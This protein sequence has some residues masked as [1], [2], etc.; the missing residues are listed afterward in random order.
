MSA[1][2]Y[3]LTTSSQNVRPRWQSYST[4]F[5]FRASG[6]LNKA[7]AKDRCKFNRRLVPV[8]NLAATS[9]NKTH[10]VVTRRI[11]AKIQRLHLRRGPVTSYLLVLAIPADSV[12]GALVQLWL[13]PLAGRVCVAAI[14]ATL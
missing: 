2:H 11:V 13:D 3:V 1:D 4:G 9:V 7:A 12:R 8:L 5:E 10:P 14:T 6:S